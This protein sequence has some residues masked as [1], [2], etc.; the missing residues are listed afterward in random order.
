MF[1]SLF[2]KSIVA[3]EPIFIVGVPRSGTTLLRVLLD[4]HPNIACGPESPW[5]ARGV[6]SIKNFYRFMAEDPLGYVQSYGVSRKRFRKQIADWVD[7]LFMEYA[8]SCGKDRWAEKTPDHSLEIPF[9]AELFPNACFVHIV[10]DGRDVACSTSILSEERKAISE[11][12][13]N[14]LLMDDGMVADNTV[15]NA[16]LRWHTWLRR[17][18]RELSRVRRSYTLRYEDLVAAPEQELKHLMTFIGEEFSPIML[19]Y[20]KKKHDYPDWEWGSRDVKRSE[21]ISTRSV[22]RWEKQLEPAVIAELEGLAGET[23][24]HYG[25]E[26]TKGKGYVQGKVHVPQRVCRLASVEELESDRFRHFMAQMN[27]FADRMDLRTF[28]D[29][30]K[31]WEY[32]WLW[33][34]ALEKMDWTGKTVLDLGSEK[35]PMPWYLASL[36]ARVTLIECDPQWIPTW[37]RLRTETGLDV[38]WHIVDSELLPFSDRSF[39][40]VTSFSVIEHQPDK[41]RAID[42]VSRVLKPGG[43]F[44]LSFDICEPGLGMTFP[45]WNGRALTMAEFEETVWSRCEFGAGGTA[46]AWNREDLTNFVHW[47][48]QSASHH[49]YAVG[50]AALE[51]LRL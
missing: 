43:L 19:D 41:Q 23:L 15:Q 17:I 2:Q 8:R 37:E 34:N 49:N 36:G 45:E 29:W 14:N 7:S 12:H 32:P 22:R 20:M 18:E 28:T 44:T 25:Y 21:G 47:H 33:F 1:K 51:K 10:R 39:D 6:P 11:W 48:Q 42:E 40:V 35:S 16:A 31:V 9:L 24:L 5:L 4:S 38:D 30:S 26:I 50:A 46:P 3:G 13:S 27:A